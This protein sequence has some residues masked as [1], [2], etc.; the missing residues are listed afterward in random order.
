ME[1]H[2]DAID[3]LVQAGVKVL[4]FDCDGVL[5]RGEEEV[6]GAREAVNRARERGLQTAFVTNNSTKS[7]REY[8]DKFRKLGMG[9]V[10]EEEIF[11]SSA[12]VA[13]HLS[14]LG[15]G[16][17]SRK[18]VYVVGEEGLTEELEA[19]GIRAEGGQ[20][21]ANK[22]PDFSQGSRLDPPDEVGAVVVGLDRSFTYYKLQRAVASIRER[23]ARFIATNYDAVAHLTA[24][25]EW[26]GA[27]AMVKAIE[28]SAEKVP[29]VV[30][31]P[32]GHAF[33]HLEHAFNVPAHEMCMIGDRLDTDIAFGL[34]HGMQTLLVFSG[35]TTPQLL[36]ESSI[37][38]H[39]QAE[40]VAALLPKEM[41]N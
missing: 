35:V 9:A 37:R 15:Y 28:A 39:F 20:R 33:K 4:L 30:G 38:P 16:P 32:N 19:V 7:R 12:M 14:S 36:K 22:L 24:A 10:S 11:P 2:S 13:S 34:H 41:K 1:L 17:A 31:K 40:S 18:S 8:A 23:G 21:D 26:S 25:Q 6:P 3:S 29:E 5:W 27:A